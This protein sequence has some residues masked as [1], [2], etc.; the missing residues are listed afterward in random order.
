[1]NGDSSIFPHIQPA[2]DPGTKQTGFTITGHEK[3]FNLGGI[4][5]LIANIGTNIDFL[6]EHP[7]AVF[8]LNDVEERDHS[9]EKIRE[10][11]STFGVDDRTPTID[12]TLVNTCLND[13][14]I[15][16]LHYLLLFCLNVGCIR[17]TRKM[18]QCALLMVLRR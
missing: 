7:I 18:P 1:M 14:K 6:D 4:S 11:K 13:Q 12:R 9:E 10:G 8:S 15:L 5:D 3:D 16:N 2:S 17:S